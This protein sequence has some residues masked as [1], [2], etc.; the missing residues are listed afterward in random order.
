MVMQVKRE[1]GAQIVDVRVSDHED[2]QDVNQL[3]SPP[4]FLN[5]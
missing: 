1:Q 3:V 5:V 4:F 2:M